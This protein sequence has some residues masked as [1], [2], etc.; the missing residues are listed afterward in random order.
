M[1][2]LANILSSFSMFMGLQNSRDTVLIYLDEP[3]CPK[4]LL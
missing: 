3:E 2:F 4:D 1:N